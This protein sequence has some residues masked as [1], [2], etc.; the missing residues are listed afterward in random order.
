MSNYATVPIVEEYVKGIAQG[1][2]ATDAL[3]PMDV[4]EK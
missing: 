2:L 1:V 4:S 3:P